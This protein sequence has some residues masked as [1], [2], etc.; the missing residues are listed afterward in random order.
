MTW[1]RITVYFALSLILGGYYFAFEW[2][3]NSEKPI[4]DA[5]PVVLNRF[6]PIA[7]EDIHEL[8]LRHAN[9]VVR[10]KRKG[11][12]WEVVEPAEA[13]VTSAVVTSLVESLTVE[14]EVQVVDQSAADFAPYG[15]AQPFST[16]EIRGTEQKLL[17]TV[18]VGNRNPTE[19]AVYARKEN[20][21]QVVLLGYSVRYYEELILEAAGFSAK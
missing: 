21:P 19:S 7:R 16:L 20:S 1:R 8:V 6:L 18:F 15:L 12:I 4:R 11:E 14:K 2:R 9:A 5:R 17:A 13:K 10:C 3:P